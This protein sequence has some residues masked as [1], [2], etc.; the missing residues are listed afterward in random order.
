[1]MIFKF[2]HSFY[3]YYDLNAC[4]FTFVKYLF[5]VCEN[6]I[7]F[8]LRSIN[9]NYTAR[10][11]SIEPSVCSQGKTHIGFIIIFF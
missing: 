4:S 3:I 5:S 11:A 6:D 2:L 1:M 7:I 8:P 10:S 9:I